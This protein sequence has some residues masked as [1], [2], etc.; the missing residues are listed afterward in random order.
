MPARMVY[1][2]LAHQLRRHGKE[3]R[4]VLHFGRCL[5]HKFE[6]GLVD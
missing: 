2:D 6:V 1:E 5:I 3:V 4:A